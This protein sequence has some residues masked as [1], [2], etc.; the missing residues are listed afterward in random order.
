LIALYQDRFAFQR[1]D[2]EVEIYDIE[3]SKLVGRFNIEG[4]IKFADISNNLLLIIT[5]KEQT[6]Y[7]HFF[8]LNPEPNVLQPLIT[9]RAVYE[10][11]R[12][13]YYKFINLLTTEANVILDKKKNSD[14]G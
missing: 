5:A 3:E 11:G 4:S 9:N 2:K 14:F 10:K 13:D 12:G 1:R 6:D 8:V 7:F